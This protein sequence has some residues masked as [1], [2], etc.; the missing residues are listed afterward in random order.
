MHV[1]QIVLEAHVVNFVKPRAALVVALPRVLVHSMQTR[2]GDLFRERVICGGDHPAFGGGEILGGVET[3]T[4]DVADGANLC[5]PASVHVAR[6]TG[7]V[8]GVFHDFQIVIACD[9]QDPIHV[10]SLAGEVHGQEG[11]D[12]F[13]RA[14]LECLLDAGW[15]DVEGAGID[16]DEDW[17]G[18]EVA[19]NF[20]GRGEGERGGDDFVAGTDAERPQ[21]QMK[22]A[23]AVRQRERMFGAD[24]FG[25]LGLETFGLGAGRDPSGAECVENLALFLGSNRRTMKT[26]LSHRV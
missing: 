26:H 24:V 1:G 2:D 23:G 15:A 20:R 16:V 4:G 17:A 10:A 9:L 14:V 11:A 18:A 22:R 21:R 8:R 12:S 19:E 13:V 3:E 5:H 6:G 7:C 25:E